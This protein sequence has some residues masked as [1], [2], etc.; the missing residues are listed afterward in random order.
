MEF[1]TALGLEP[2][3]ELDLADLERRYYAASRELH[4]DRFARAP[5][6]QQAE[7]LAKS[8]LLTRAYRTLRDP[9]A[10]AEYIL[11]QKGVVSKDLPP[12]FLEQAFEW[13]ERVEE[14]GEAERENLRA[15]LQEVD[16]AL[17]ALYARWDAS[18]D[19]ATLREIR[20][21]LNQRRYIENLVHG[22]V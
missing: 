19:E 15:M 17:H 5:A 22:H 20:R 18:R 10:R 7:A 9:H 21:T 4:P 2:A 12:G 8:S 14:G 6:A 13:N 3:F 1:F 11:E 16:A